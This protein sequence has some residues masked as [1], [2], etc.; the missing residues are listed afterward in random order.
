MKQYYDIIVIGGGHAGTEAS[1]ICSVLGANTLLITNDENKIGE[2]SCNPAIGGLGK[3]HLVREIDALGGLMPSASDFSGIQFRL[4]NRS[5]GPAVQ[6]PRTQIDRKVYKNYVYNSLVG[7]KNLSILSEEVSS[8][9]VDNNKIKGVVLSDRKKIY[10]KSIILTTG[11]FLNGKIH[12]GD[13]S[14]SGGRKGDSA[15]INLAD[16]LYD[17]KLPMGRLKTGTPPRLLA[18]TINWKELEKQKADIE[19]VF[20]SFLTTKVN[21]EQID[22][23]ITYTNSETHKI[24]RENIQKSAIFNGNISSK[25]PRYCPSI[26]D[27][28]HRF[29]DKDRHQ[30]FLE[31]EGLNSNVVYPN[32]ISTSLPEKTQLEFLS[33]IKGL[34]KVQILQPG[35]A[36]EY[37]YVDPRSLKQSL[38][39]KKVNG[40][41]LAGQ[42]NGTTGYE[43]AASQG[44]IA[45][46]NA[47]RY[48]KSQNPF[49]IGR[50]EG[51][52][53]VLIDDLT[54]KGVLEPY[55]MF[56][57]RAEFRL[58]LRADNADQRLT[59]TGLKL[60]TI[61]SLRKKLFQNKMQDIKDAMILFK[62]LK[63]SPNQA[64]II[65]I[66]VKKDGKKRTAFDLLGQ[67]P[68]NIEKMKLIW[69]DVVNVDFKVINQL[70]NIAKYEVYIDR[71]KAEVEAIKKYES[72]KI[73]N[74]LEYKKIKGLS[75]EILTKLELIR[76][77]NLLQASR[78]EG[79][80]P[81]AMTLLNLHIKRKRL[82]QKEKNLLQNSYVKKSA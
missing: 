59:N 75:N 20:F 40:F 63:I 72:I 31:P 30:I 5:K 7:L 74:D 80:T 8:L 11:T 9:V 39:L 81:A 12:I 58:L 35:Y 33:T 69:P 55:R 71:Q 45:G 2:M 77:T 19:P 49:I 79:V 66:K 3:G 6:G 44:I 57:S 38:E 21:L 37:D 46:I 47:Y 53:G 43:E 22:C 82:F 26:E 73:P 4:L 54:T 60:G 78:I 1:H 61:S 50:D 10:A 51:Y 17:L 16:F 23:Y 24:I 68:E 25:G 56:T 52:I 28:V 70:S 36:I 48:L 65:G 18:E 62:S 27:K 64:E 32:G 13:K 41:F 29:S 14:F 76:P 15:S 34:E 42:I 67:S